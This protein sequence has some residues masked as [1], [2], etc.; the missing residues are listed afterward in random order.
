MLTPRRRSTRVECDWFLTRGNARSRRRKT[1]PGHTGSISRAGRWRLDV[2]DQHAFEFELDRAISQQVIEKLSK[3]PVHSL[4]PTLPPRKNGVY[5]LYWRK[6][7][8]YGGKASGRTS[9]RSRLADHYR[10][11]AGRRNIDVNEMTCRWLEI[12]SEWFVWAAEQVVITA[13]QGKWNASGFGGHAPGIGRPGK[14]GPNR[15]DRQF[16]P[17]LVVHPRKSHVPPR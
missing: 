12:K 17:R 15:W 7:F 14:R 1:T 10:K 3:S 16:P 8:V 5:A 4:S 2:C 11:I 9:L 6:R 13:F